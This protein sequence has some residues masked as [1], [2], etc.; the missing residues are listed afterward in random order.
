[1]TGRI[2]R[3][4]TAPA[5]LREGKFEVR[6]LFVRSKL[7]DT[8]KDQF[9]SSLSLLLKLLCAKQQDQSTVSHYNLN[10]GNRVTKTSGKWDTRETA[11][12]M[13]STGIIT[14]NIA[15]VPV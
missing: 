15:N 6:E 14:L 7:L 3:K 13:K 2:S 1:M 11:M 12:F 5:R 9:W 8:N 10:N 4:R